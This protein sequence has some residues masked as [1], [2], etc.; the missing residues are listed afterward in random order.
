[1][2]THQPVLF[3]EAITGLA[4]KPDGIYVD[5][6]FGRGGHSF[7]IL[8]QLG[9]N[10]RLIALDKDPEAI[11]VA[12]RTPFLDPRFCIEH[13]SFA[14][15]KDVAMQHEIV[16]KIDGVLL[17]AGVSSPQLDDPARG[18]SFTKEGPLDMRMNTQQGMDAATWVSQA[19]A[20]DISRVLKHYGEERYSRRI[21]NA[22]VTAREE[23]HITTTT[24]LADIIA[25]ACPQRELHKH[26]ATRSFQAI[27]I[28]I[29][30]ELEDLTNCLE[31]TIDVLSVRGRMSVISFHSLEDRIVKQFIQKHSQGDPYP[32]NFPIKDVDLP[33]RM[34]K[35][36]RLIRPTAKEV[37]EN[38]RARS[39]RLRIAEKIK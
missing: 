29:N 21:A 36:G 13:A 24:Q 16:G 35:I 33:R 22:I 1:M 38:P 10:G 14:E 25:N 6:T 3:E 8:R 18:F 17:D 28:Y 37:A 5:A 11:E 30:N 27:R 26:P 7:G 34:R 4:I 9:T 19:S 39:A 31:Q 20:D 32:S 15:L 2:T 23:K 12:K